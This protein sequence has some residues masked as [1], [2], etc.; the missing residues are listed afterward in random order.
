MSF[1]HF[2][3]K[4]RRV[5]DFQLRPPTQDEAYEAPSAGNGHFDRHCF[6][7]VSDASERLDL[8]LRWVILALGEDARGHTVGAQPH[9]YRLA[10]NAVKAR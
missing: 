8:A 3:A 5:N 4:L 9:R 7:A 2:L 10:V 6:L 1:G